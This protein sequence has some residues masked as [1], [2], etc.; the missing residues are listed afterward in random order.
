M[1]CLF[2]ST[3]SGYRC[4]SLIHLLTNGRCQE[5]HLHPQ[6]QHNLCKKRAI[7]LGNWMI[8]N[9]W[10]VFGC[11]LKEGR[12]G[13]FEFFISDLKHSSAVFCKG[14]VH[15]YSALLR[16]WM[17]TLELH[18]SASFNQKPFLKAFTL[19]PPSPQKL[20]F[21]D[22]EPALN[23]S[24][25]LKGKTNMLK[26]CDLPPSDG[27]LFSLRPIRKSLAVFLPPLNA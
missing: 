21:C 10:P 11:F 8:R 1:L 14:R 6:R 16:G 13:K 5:L 25:V 20:C 19:L 26:G 2:W 17:Y 4:S 22:G 3:P 9:I 7:S 15:H 23:L 12:F 24:A 18:P 27:C